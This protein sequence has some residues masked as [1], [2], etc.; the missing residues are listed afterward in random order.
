VC[1]C[2]DVSF[3]GM[4]VHF[5]QLFQCACVHGPWPNWN[6]SGRRPKICKAI[7]RD[8][9]H[10]P[11][12]MSNSIVELYELRGSDLCLLHRL[13]QTESASWLPPSKHQ[14]GS[15]APHDVCQPRGQRHRCVT[16]AVLR[17]CVHW[18]PSLSH[19]KSDLQ[20]C[21]ASMKELRDRIGSVNNTRKITDAMKLVAAAKVR[22][23]QE[24]VV[25]G[26]PFSE[27]LV[28]ASPHPGFKHML[29]YLVMIRID[30]FVGNFP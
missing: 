10:V 6:C 24:A 15:V 28:K 14:L 30:R 13:T 4:V 29:Q 1:G 16:D 26:R 7:E 22:R 3:Q 18:I 17:S 19:R 8:R 27:N 11:Q 2:S 5:T 9:L 21:S 12:Y 25:N 20:V 23:A